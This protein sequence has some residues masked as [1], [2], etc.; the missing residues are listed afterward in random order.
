MEKPKEEWMEW[1]EGWWKEELE[2]EELQGGN[3]LCYVQGLY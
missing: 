1:A 3:A 2:M